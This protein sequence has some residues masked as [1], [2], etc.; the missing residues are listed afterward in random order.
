MENHYCPNVSLVVSCR[1]LQLSKLRPMNVV[2]DLKSKR[3]RPMLPRLM[4]K[5]RAD[6]YWQ[7]DLLTINGLSSCSRVSP[8]RSSLHRR[9][10]TQELFLLGPVS[11][12]G[13]RPANVSRKLAGYRSLSAGQPNQ[14][15]S[16]GHPRPRLS[17]HAGQRQLGTRL[18]HLRRLR[19]LA[20]PTGTSALPGRRV[21]PGAAANCLRARCHDY[22]S[23]PLAISL[24]L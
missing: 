7:I 22:R 23:L 14:A 19:S 6:E 1:L 18:A 10:Q 11:M 13:L 9:L 17:Q 16:H 12:H 8:M 20:D 21:Q 5:E 2:I 15:L 3:V 24:G 4:R